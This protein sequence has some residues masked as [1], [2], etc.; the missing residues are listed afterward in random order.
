ME[1][2]TLCFLILQ[3]AHRQKA[4]K[5]RQLRKNNR[6]SL[7]YYTFCG[8]IVFG[9]LSVVL[10]LFSLT[11]SIA[12]TVASFRSGEH[13]SMYLSSAEAWNMLLFLNSTTHDTLLHCYL[14]LHSVIE[15]VFAFELIS[16]DPTTDAC[17][18]IAERLMV[19]HVGMKRN[20]CASVVEEI[21]CGDETARICY[22]SVA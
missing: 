9:G 22:A 17:P 18:Q 1:E 21:S 16:T 10:A 8:D 4:R 11:M 3:T 2:M 13:L 12:Q 6:D 20:V 15:L 19:R 7:K 14:L 5:I